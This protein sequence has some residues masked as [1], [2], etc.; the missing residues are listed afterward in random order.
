MRQNCLH[1]EERESSFEEEV[2][3]VNFRYSDYQ[4]GHSGELIKTRFSH[5]GFRGLLLK[6]NK[7]NIT[8]STEKKEIDPRMSVDPLVCYYLCPS[9]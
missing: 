4:Y 9:V 7:A 2:K 5:T 8:S 6:Y 3:I 1:F